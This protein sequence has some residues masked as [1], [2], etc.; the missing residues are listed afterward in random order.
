MSRV[1]TNL[2]EG[3]MGVPPVMDA[4]AELGEKPGTAVLFN[5]SQLPD[6]VRM[7]PEHGGRVLRVLGRTR[8][9]IASC[10]SCKQ[11]GSTGGYDLEDRWVV[12]TCAH[13]GLYVWGRR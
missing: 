2:T 13:C 7:P 5:A 6:V 11:A 1:W 4:S 10:P 12:G 8:F 3:R 9:K